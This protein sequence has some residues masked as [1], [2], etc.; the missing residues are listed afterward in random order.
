[1]I[2]VD[3]HQL[4]HGNPYFLNVHV[5]LEETVM[6]YRHFLG[7]EYAFFLWLDV[8]VINK[9]KNDDF[10]NIIHFFFLKLTNRSPERTSNNLIRFFPSRKSTY[11]SPI[12]VFTLTKCELTHFW[13]VFF[14]TLSRSSEIK[15]I[16]HKYVFIISFI[17]SFLKEKSNRSDCL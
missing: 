10:V 7:S 14:C 17:N 13:K 8:A 6:L 2:I 16:V 3:F 12:R 9:R 11:K 15:Q 1:M 5:V 4:Y